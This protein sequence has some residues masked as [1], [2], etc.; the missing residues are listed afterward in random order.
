[1]NESIYHVYANY[2]GERRL[3]FAG[4]A[5]R[6]AR[7]VGMHP[8]QLARFHLEQIS[9]QIAPTTDRF[10]NRMP[11]QLWSAPVTLYRQPNPEME[12]AE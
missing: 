9:I 5:G 6:V 11:Y 10:G 2:C 3:L 4:Y 7:R 8:S 12:I 1:M